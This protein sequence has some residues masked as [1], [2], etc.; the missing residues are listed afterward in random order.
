MTHLRIEEE[1]EAVARKV[2]FADAHGEHGVQQERLAGVH[3][4]LDEQRADA[5]VLDDAAQ[6]LF[7]RSSAAR[8]S[9][10][11]ASRWCVRAVLLTIVGWKFRRRAEC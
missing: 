10:Q 7:E 5:D 8:A 9:E 11:N 4:G 3:L 2:A 6:A 1:D